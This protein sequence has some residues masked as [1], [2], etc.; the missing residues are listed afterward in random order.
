MEKKTYKVVV[1]H[2]KYRY[3]AGLDVHKDYVMACVAVQRG[4]AIEKV[5][6]QEFKQS[7]PG[8]ADLCRFR[9]KYLLEIVVM[10]ATG[11]YTPPVK[12]A[13]DEHRGWGMIKPAIVVINPS[14]VRKFPGEPHQDNRDALDLAGLGLRGMTRGSFIPA[15]QARELRSGTREMDFV[16]RDCTRAKNRIKRVLA[17]WGLPLPKLD[18]DS[19]WALDLFRAIDWAG[20]NF[21][22]ALDGFWGEN[23]RSRRPASA[24]LLAAR[25]LTPRMDP[26]NYPRLPAW[27]SGVTSSHCPSTSLS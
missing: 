7:P 1:P 14:L 25:Q 11:V 13:L 24:V 23:L 16:T 27:C 5:A 4:A 10:E 6:I 26:S 22:R 18:L 17:E 19:N 12:Q 20:G 8:L 3:G 15:G 2:A 9:G 21:G